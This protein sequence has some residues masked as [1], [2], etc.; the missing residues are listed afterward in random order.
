MLCVALGLGKPRARRFP[1]RTHRVCVCACAPLIGCPPRVFSPVT[2]VALRVTAVGSRHHI[3]LP[4]SCLLLPLLFGI[5]V[6]Q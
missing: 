2:R 1:A 4:A 3:A 5:C 6:Y